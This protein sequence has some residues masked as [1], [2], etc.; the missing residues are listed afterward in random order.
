MRFKFPH[1]AFPAIAALAL[2]ACSAPTDDG[3]IHDPYESLNRVSHTFN[4]GADRVLVRPL[5]RA[6]GATVPS[7]VRRS[8]S[9]VASH[10]DEPKSIANHVLQGDAESA[11]HSFFRFLVN[12]TVGVAGLF[13]PAAGS[14]GLERRQTGFGDT[15]AAWGARE[16]AYL[17]LPF[18]G[19][20]T[21]RDFVGLIFDVA[22]NPVSHISSD[23]AVL[24]TA[25]TIPAA[26][27]VR[28]EFSDT[29]DSVLRDSADSYAQLRLS[30]IQNRK[31]NL[32]EQ[33]PDGAGHDPFEDLYDEIYEELY[34][35]F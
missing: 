14:F 16:G 28:Y 24:N 8:L 19:P 33:N 35:E 12:S 31:F 13:D 26:L 9:Q 23:V 20:S 3:A 10:L 30:Y 32:N 25:S 17:E 34:D 15:L 29:V 1:L 22:T 2:S 7:P 21:E 11:G 5:S 6:Y 18:A 4:K 27:N